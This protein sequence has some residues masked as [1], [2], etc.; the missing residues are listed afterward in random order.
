MAR[1]KKKP[2]P[3]LLHENNWDFGIRRKLIFFWLPQKKVMLQV[4]FNYILWT[5]KVD[6]FHKSMVTTPNVHTVFY[7][8]VLYTF[9]RL[10][11]KSL[12][13]FCNPTF[14]TMDLNVKQKTIKWTDLNMHPSNLEI[15]KSVYY[16]YSYLSQLIICKHIYKIQNKW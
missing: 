1:S 15:F 11:W 4:Y 12:E 14:R 6:N 5:K 16:F 13:P 2:S 9:L 8:I 7:G 3:S 10:V